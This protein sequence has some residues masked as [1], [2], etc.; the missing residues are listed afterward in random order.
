MMR[1]TDAPKALFYA[2]AHCLIPCCREKGSQKTRAKEARD[3]QLPCERNVQ[4]PQTSRWQKQDDDVRYHVKDALSDDDWAMVMAMA[5]RRELVPDHP[6]W[7]AVEHSPEHEDS[8]EDKQGGYHRPR[9]VPHRP[10]ELSAWGE[11]PD[12]LQQ[13]SHFDKERHW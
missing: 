6:T 3:D 9:P 8:V 11:K 5:A 1:P 7:V 13:D 2:L 4:L 12:V 10:V